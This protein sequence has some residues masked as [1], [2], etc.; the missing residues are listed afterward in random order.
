SIAATRS[1]A[2][3]SA[4]VTRRLSAL[5]ASGRFSLSQTTAASASSSTSGA[6]T[7]GLLPAEGAEG[8]NG[9]DREARGGRERHRPELRSKERQGEE[10][11]APVAGTD[12]SLEDSVDQRHRL[13]HEHLDR[14]LGER[15]IGAPGIAAVR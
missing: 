13:V 11:R 15:R 9:T 10:R 5:R 12:G 14:R 4:S 7:I 3:S 6:S 8:D 2:S 1:S